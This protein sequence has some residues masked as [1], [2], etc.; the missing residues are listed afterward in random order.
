MPHALDID[1]LKTFIAI[2]DN[3]SF[4][5]A[6]DEVHK[7]QSAVSMQ[8]KRLEEAVGRPLFVRDGRQSR[9]T[10]DGESLLDYARRIVKLSDEAVLSFSEPEIAGLVRIGTPDD[11]ADRFLPPILAWFSRTHPHVQLQVECRPSVELV[12]L[13]RSGRLD[14]SL[15]TFGS[16]IFEGEVIRKEQLV[17][18]TSARHCVHEEDPVPLALSHTGCAW[19]SLALDS[20]EAVGRETRIALSSPNSAAMAAAVLTGLAV[21]AIPESTTR[22]GMRIL[23]EADGYPDLGDFDIG[24]VRSREDLPGAAHALAEH[25]REG[26]ASIGRKAGDAPVSMVAAE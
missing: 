12:E 26:L 4:T 23:S 21:S 22:P 16:G 17:W 1:L 15:V 11:Y 19:R 24:L 13:T 2:A 25:L 14:L 18:V 7:T 3:G 8:M 10:A 20:L 6:A 5:R 9:L